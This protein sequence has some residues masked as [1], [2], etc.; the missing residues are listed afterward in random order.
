MSVYEEVKAAGGYIANHE[1]DLYIE[2]N[3]TN[4][5][6]LSRHPLQKSNATTFRNQVTG[7]LCFDVPFAYDPFWTGSYGQSLHEA[8]AAH[9]WASRKE[10]DQQRR[11]IYDGSGN[12][13]GSFD[14]KE[15]W[16]FLCR[17]AT[18]KTALQEKE[19]K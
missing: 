7:A 18:V 15:A 4:R 12:R 16:A 17:T 11:T 13:L 3:D 6:I 1:S 19:E 2:V 9:G 10:N 5:A 8:I 14:A